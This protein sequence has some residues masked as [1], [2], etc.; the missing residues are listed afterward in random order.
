MEM[1]NEMPREFI[2]FIPDEK[3]D[4]GIDVRQDVQMELE[5]PEQEADKEDT[6]TENEEEVKPED[7]ICESMRGPSRPKILRTGMRGRPRKIYNLILR[8]ESANA[9]YLDKAFIADIPLTQAIKGSDAEAWYDAMS[10]EVTSIIENDTWTLVDCPCN[11][12][13]IGSRI[14]LRT[15][16]GQTKL[17]REGRL[18][19]LLR[20]LANDLVYTLPKRS[21]LWYDL[22]LSD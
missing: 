13:V 12:E 7:E 16:T 14:V 10:D 4:Q 11:E 1:K 15:N 5:S 22:V 18:G 6:V 8:E 9:E 3:D 2:D 17:S 21:H 19:W 20:A